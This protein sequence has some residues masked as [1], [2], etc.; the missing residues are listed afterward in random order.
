M[1]CKAQAL[2][3]LLLSAPFLCSC[4]EDLPSVSIKTLPQED[5]VS[6]ASRLAKQSWWVRIG[7]LLYSP[8]L[9][10]AYDLERSETEAMD[11]SR[12]HYKYALGH[13][14]KELQ[15]FRVGGTPSLHLLHSPDNS[16]DLE[17]IA[18]KEVK[19]HGACRAFNGVLYDLE[20]AGSTLKGPWQETTSPNSFESSLTEEEV[21]AL[22][23]QVSKEKIEENM[24]KLTGFNTRNVRSEEVVQARD[25]ITQQ[26]A[27]YGLTVQSKTSNLERRVD[28]QFLEN[29][30]GLLE[31]HGGQEVVVV[32]A[33]YDDLPDHPPAPGAEDNASGV[34][35][36]LEV[37]RVLSQAKKTVQSLERSAPF[38]HHPVQ[39]VGFGG[40]E[41]GLKGSTNFVNQELKPQQKVRAAVIMDEVGWK[42]GDHF[43]VQLETKNVDNNNRLK[44]M[45]GREGKAHNTDLEITQSYNPYGSDHMPFIN[46]GL[47]A[48][49]LINTD[50]EAYPNYHQRSDELNEQNINYDLMHKIAKMEVATVAKIANPKSNTAAVTSLEKRRRSAKKMHKL[51]KGSKGG[52]TD[53]ERD[54]TTEDQ[55]ERELDLS[56]NSLIKDLQK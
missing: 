29:A 24:K 43:G 28:G 27:S 2:H 4:M 41:V 19:K 56:L 34:A 13:L 53:L 22:V 44:D 12:S 20:K 16:L 30:H 50:D 38:P 25:W 8:S 51:L 40:E 9:D 36:M 45:L 55:F 46:K 32:G 23:D 10:S 5:F 49:L 39:F 15:S 47:P 48:V 26:F 7:D 18:K 35:V 31:G 17:R 21:K 3:Y 42:A 52:A 14:P 6:L 33:H 11:T 37:A 1:V 54:A